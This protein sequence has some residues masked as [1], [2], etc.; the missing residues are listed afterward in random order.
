MAALSFAMGVVQWLLSQGIFEVIQSLCTQGLQGVVSL[1]SLGGLKWAICA[2]FGP[3]APMGMMMTAVTFLVVKDTLEGKFTKDPAGDKEAQLIE[4]AVP[5]IQ[6]A[7][8]GSDG[9]S[10]W[11]RLQLFLFIQADFFNSAMLTL[12]FNCLLPATMASWSLLSKNG[13]GFKS[14]VASRRTSLS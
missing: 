9:M 7:V 4:L 10:L 11:K 12:V 3:V 2:I 6:G 8:V 1:Q 13:A 14:I 5:D